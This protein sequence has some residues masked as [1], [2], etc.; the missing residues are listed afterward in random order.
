MLVLL[1]Q[2]AILPD[3]GSLQRNRQAAMFN[4]TLGLAALYICTRIIFSYP[5]AENDISVLL[6]RPIALSICFGIHLLLK[7]GYLRFTSYLF[8]CLSVATAAATTLNQ[9]YDGINPYI[10]FPALMIMASLIAGSDGVLWTGFFAAGFSL[11]ASAM[12]EM[13]IFSVGILLSRPFSLGLTYVVYFVIITYLL[14][15]GARSMEEL[16]EKLTRMNKTLSGEIRVRTRTADALRQSQVELNMTLDNAPIGILTFE[17]DGQM[18]RV[19]EAL[20]D[21]I[22]CTESKIMGMCVTDLISAENQA[23]F[24]DRIQLLQLGHKF[25]EPLEQSLN[26]NTGETR[27]TYWRV[28]LILDVEQ[29]PVHFVASIEDITERRKVQHQ[30]QL[31]QKHEGIG[32]LAGGIAHDFNNLLVS[33]LGQSSLALERARRHKSV[34]SNVQKVIK[35][36]NK[37]ALLTKQLLAYAGRGQIDMN[38]MSIQQVLDDNIQLLDVAL[39]AGIEMRVDCAPNLPTIMGDIGQIQ[40]VV[41]NLIINAGEAMPNGGTIQIKTEELT[42]DAQTLATWKQ[43]KDSLTPGEYVLLEVSDNGSG[44][45]EATRTRIFDPFFTTRLGQGGSGLG[46]NI[47]YN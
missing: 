19:N 38:P 30:F 16:L 23:T 45:D 36:A 21:M 22:G 29:T 25:T 2:M 11:V 39:P 42:L 8:L 41:M 46:L 7:R 37:A 15:V 13:H 1:R 12:N 40:Q 14:Y 17:L 26:I 9:S 5:V 31:A 4:V 10:F 27:Q 18:L 3:Y 34:E 20:C 6:R 28:A 43:A 32:I 33:I 24:A 35:A 47:V 44:M